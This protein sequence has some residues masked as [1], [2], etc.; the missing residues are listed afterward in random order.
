MTI[1]EGIRQMIAP[2]HR[3]ARAKARAKPAHLKGEKV[4]QIDRVALLEVVRK[5]GGK[6]AAPRVT[7]IA[8]SL[9]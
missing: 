8:L 3:K 1:A 4:A 7:A 9:V 6:I 2:A 5:A